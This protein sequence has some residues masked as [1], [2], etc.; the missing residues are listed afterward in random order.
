MHIESEY[1][2]INHLICLFKLNKSSKSTL[3]NALDINNNGTFE[4]AKHI[5]TLIRSEGVY[6][7]QRSE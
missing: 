1:L 7:D 4:G 5:D 3:L 6:L 2:S